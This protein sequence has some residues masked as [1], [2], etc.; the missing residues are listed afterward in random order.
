MKYYDSEIKSLKAK[1]LLDIN[2]FTTVLG[3]N[4]KWT[5]PDEMV[6]SK[7]AFKA[8]EIAEQ[9]MLHKAIE[10]FTEFMENYCEESGR[11]DIS[12]N[13]EHYIKI[14]TELLDK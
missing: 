4:A 7:N 13:S 14:F 1:E 11:T 10:A 2:S 6:S 3:T 8:I 5:M 9:E 12:N